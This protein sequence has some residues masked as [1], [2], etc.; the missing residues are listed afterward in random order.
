MSRHQQHDEPRGDVLVTD[1]GRWTDRLGRAPIRLTGDLDIATAPQV[2]QELREALIAEPVVVLDLRAVEFM[3]VVGMRVIVE[4]SCQARQD[5]R[6]VMVERGPEHVDDVFVLTGMDGMIDY[7]GV[8]ADDGP[9]ARSL[10][11][12]IRDVHRK[13]DARVEARLQAH[14]QIV[15]VP[16]AAHP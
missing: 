3:D 16:E 12:F 13:L 14:L 6:R 11:A 7:L 2:A 9:A 15:R 5:G 1:H 8:G 4:A 10:T